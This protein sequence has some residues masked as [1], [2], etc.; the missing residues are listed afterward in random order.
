[1]DYTANNATD[2][3]PTPTCGRLTFCKRRLLSPC[4][5]SLN[6]I[7]IQNKRQFRFCLLLAESTPAEQGRHTFPSLASDV[8][9]WILVLKLLGRKRVARIGYWSVQALDNKGIT[10]KSNS[11]NKIIF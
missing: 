6:A 11:V 7:F 9:H 4:L 1:M 2:N 5:F 8:Y 3:D 10:R